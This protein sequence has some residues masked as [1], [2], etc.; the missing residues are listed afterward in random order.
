MKAS[1]QGRAVARRADRVMKARRRG[2]SRGRKAT[3][4][5]P[6]AMGEALAA[7]SA[8]TQ[9]HALMDWQGEAMV[10]LRAIRPAKDGD[11]FAKLSKLMVRACHRAIIWNADADP[12]VA[13][14]QEDRRFL[15]AGVAAMLA[16]VAKLQALADRHKRGF[17]AI[18]WRALR[19]ARITPEMMRAAGYD[20]EAGGQG[21]RFLRTFLAAFRDQLEAE[22]HPDTRRAIKGKDAGGIQRHVHGPLRF[23]KI[24]DRG[25]M[26]DARMTGLQFE[27]AFYLRRY[28][29]GRKAREIMIDDTLPAYGRPHY[30][31][32]AEFCGMAL[33]HFPEDNGEA[34]TKAI[35]SNTGADGEPVLW[36]GWGAP[37]GHN[38]GDDVIVSWVSDTDD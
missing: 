21:G 22:T 33:D 25:R 10:A 13:Q 14:R 15:N 29:A 27:L 30:G 32:I 6:T 12:Y 4:R 16:A 9:G 37:E 31:I 20:G 23:P 18:V 3:I 8:A 35:K 28:T 19:V 26:P 17:D 2:C 1:R 38:V 11:N 5:T 34:F 24:V 36:W 7:K